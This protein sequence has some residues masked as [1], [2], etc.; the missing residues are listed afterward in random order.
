MAVDMTATMPIWVRWLPMLL[1]LLVG[2]DLNIGLSMVSSLVHPMR[3]IYVEY[4]KNSE[5]EGGGT[6]YAPFRKI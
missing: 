1:I 5:F 6:A 2:H 3:L 4:Y